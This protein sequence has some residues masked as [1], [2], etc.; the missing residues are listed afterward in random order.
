[1]IS[2]AYLACYDQC[3]FCKKVRTT[4]HDYPGAITSSL[5]GINSS[6]QIVKNYQNTSGTHGFI[7]NGAIMLGVVNLPKSGIIGGAGKMPDMLWIW[8]VFRALISFQS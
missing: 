8:E 5:N 4:S 1:M 3:L 7:K 2:L 6:G